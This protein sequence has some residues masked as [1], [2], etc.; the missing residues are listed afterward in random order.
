MNLANVMDELGTKLDPIPGLRVKAY[1]ADSV[2]PPVA[3]VSLPDGIDFD[4][5]YG[6]GSD[7]MT[8]VVDVL[9]GKVSDRKSRDAIARYADGSGSH[10]VKQAL[11]SSNTN[12]YQSC[13]AVTVASVDFG[14]SDEAGIDYLAGRF[15]VNVTGS[16]S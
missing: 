14:V 12:T 3:I 6:R 16:G 7:S 4:A 11:D 5:T 1:N 2:V 15:T 8:L 10:S 13:D 9:V